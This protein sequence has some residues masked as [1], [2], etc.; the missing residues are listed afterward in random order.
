MLAGLRCDDLLLS[1]PEAARLHRIPERTVRRRLL[2]AG[3]R[4][5][6]RADRPRYRYAD[7]AALLEERR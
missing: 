6:G 7:L 5:Y 4:P 2:A 1:V 3:V